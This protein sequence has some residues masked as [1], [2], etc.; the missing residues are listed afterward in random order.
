[1]PAIAEQTRREMLEAEVDAAGPQAKA[2][3]VQA[4]NTGAGIEFAAMCALRQAPGAKNTDRAFQEGARRQMENMDPENA[5]HVLASARKAGINPSGKYYKGSLGR[6]TDPAAWVSTA[7][8][9]VAS[10]K[11]KKLDV[12]G[13]VNVKAGPSELPPPKRVAL[14]EDVARR[15]EGR[16]LAAEPA[17]A[18]KCR[19]SA[20]ARRELR[21]RVIAKHGRKSR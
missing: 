12:S 7:D 10:A 13:V 18:E 6:Y 1:M 16:I 11:A 20:S 2:I 21:D 17:T 4:L 5:R 19:K 8:D 14:A 15:L 3:Y 9:V